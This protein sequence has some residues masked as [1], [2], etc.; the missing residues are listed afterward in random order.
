MTEFATRL[1]WL[2]SRL[3]QEGARYLVVGPR[4][5]QLWGSIRAT[6][7]IAILIAPSVENAAR[8]LRALEQAGFRLARAWLAEAVAGRQVT[9]IGGRHRV[10]ILTV[11]G[12]VDFDQAEPMATRFV[13]EGVAIPTA[14]RDHLVAFARAGWMSDTADLEILRTTRRQT[15]L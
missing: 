8:V 5:L 9:V 15:A 4:A 2:C 10:D 7:D 14:S 1:A 13:I 12:I 11:A 3:N 6:R